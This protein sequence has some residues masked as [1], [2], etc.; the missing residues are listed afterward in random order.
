MPS[1]ATTGTGD[2]KW[3]FA[4]ISGTQRGLGKQH[5]EDS[6]HGIRINISI[7]T[8]SA[9]H[10]QVLNYEKLLNCLPPEAR[11]LVR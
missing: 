5:K 7:P 3:R 2:A 8:K 11:V 9:V 4:Y 10:L 6:D 1:D